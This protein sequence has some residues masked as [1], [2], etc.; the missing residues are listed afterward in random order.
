MK[1]K[2]LLLL[3]VLLLTSC[4]DIS[5]TTTPTSSSSQSSESS[6]SSTS[7][8]SSSSDDREYLEE[9]VART[10]LYSL[11]E[12]SHNVHIESLVNIYQVDSYSIDLRQEISKDLSFS[13]DEV[14]EGYIERGYR[15]SGYRRY[16]DLEKET[17]EPIE[18]TEQVYDYPT[19]QIYEDRESGLAYSEEITL[20]NEV[21]YS[22]MANYDD[23]T[24]IYDPVSFAN[25]YRNPFDYISI[26]DFYY[27]EDRSIHLDTQKAEFIAEC[28]D[29]TSIN[30]ISD[31]IVSLNSDGYISYI[32]FVTPDLV[33][34]GRYTRTSQVEL[35]FS[36]FGEQVITHLAP[37]DNDNPEL[38]EALHILDDVTSYTYT[39]YFLDE[40]GNEV[41]HT[42][43]YFDLNAGM[44][45]FHQ[46]NP[47]YDLDPNEM[48]TAGDNYDYCVVYQEDGDYAGQ[49]L[50]YEYVSSVLGWD[51]NL[52]M[53]SSTAPYVLSTFSDIGPNFDVLNS[54]LF[55]HEGDSYVAPDE[56]VSTL[57]FYFDNG[58]IGVQSGAFES[59]TTTLAITLDS[60]GD[61]FT[62]ETGFE[63]MGEEYFVRFE[64]SDI[65]STELPSY[66]LETWN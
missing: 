22:L 29:L 49:W 63:I 1:N 16:A 56:L 9:S 58:F 15:E 52:I 25:T 66:F 50:G 35:S 30:F 65:N 57:G 2:L 36:D 14:E 45:F 34:E 61:G 46:V 47:N 6:N 39:K 21:N 37:Y 28:Y 59:G 44:V 40:E 24:G 10:A 12:N 51:W 3:P 17:H 33:D 55:T 27:G 62:V 41:N 11:R 64:L 4:S 53:L 8:S 43:G 32:S 23:T 31:A 19:M 42:T 5:S 18:S 54:S 7:S 38:E 13:Y 20:D 26:N 48:Y 60:E